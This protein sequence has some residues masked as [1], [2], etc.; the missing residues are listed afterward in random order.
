M[1]HGFLRKRETPK[2]RRDGRGRQAA[3]AQPGSW[4]SQDCTAS[5]GLA[6]RR[7][8]AGG[9][10]RHASRGRRVLRLVRRERGD[11]PTRRRQTPVVFRSASPAR[12]NERPIARPEPADSGSGFP[13]G[14][15][16]AGG[17]GICH[18]AGG[19]GARRQGQTDP[20]GGSGGIAVALP[21]ANAAAEL[22]YC[23][24]QTC[25]AA[26]HWS[27][28]RLAV[29]YGPDIEQATP[30]DASVSPV[31]GAAPP[32]YDRAT[33]AD[34]KLLDFDRAQPDCEMWTDWHKLCSRMGTGGATTIGP[35]P[36]IRPDPLSRFAPRAN[37]P[38]PTRSP[39]DCRAADTASGPWT[40]F[41]LSRQ[42]QRGLTTA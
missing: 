18:D 37:H 33:S 1:G 31:G 40:T 14:S 35:T 28:H 26:A 19:G 10:C 41:P 30:G 39:R 23:R 8:G 22:D 12:A 4:R 20:K 16:D 11:R 27:F 34:R 7:G 25:D 3:P 5:A 2:R 13:G 17:A 42:N 32:A 38:A 29:H 6:G 24:A 15:S 36:I 9:R 21:E